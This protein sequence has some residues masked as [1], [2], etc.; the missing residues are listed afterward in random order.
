MVAF[1]DTYSI[2]IIGLACRLPKA[3]DARAFWRNLREGVDCITRF[4]IEEL[5]DAGVPAAAAK[6]PSYVRAR[7]IIADDAGFDAALFGMSAR[8]AE[9]TDP[10]QRIWL[11]CALSALEDAGYDPRRY[12]GLI[13]V[14]A[15][16]GSPDY[17]LRWPSFGA[18][19]V[20]SH[21]V[22]I[23]NDK[24]FAA[25]RTSY[26]L[27]LRGPS[28]SLQSACSTSLAAI[29]VACQQ[30]LGYQCDMAVA[31]GA[32]LSIPSR[33]GYWYRDG[34]IL[35]PDGCCRAFDAR[36]QGTV[37]GDGVGALVLKRLPDALADGDD[38]HAVL[39]GIAVNNDG[40]DKPGYTAPS[41][42]GQRGVIEQA[43]AFAGISASAV[44]FVE[45]HGTGTPLGDPIEFAALSQVFKQAGAAPRSCALGSV[46]TNI[47]HLNVAAGVA[48][49]IKAVLAVKHRAIPPTLYFE[50]PNPAIALDDSAFYVNRELRPWSIGGP[51]IAGVSSFG[52]GGTNAHAIVSEPPPRALIFAS[53]RRF[54]IL[55]I[56]AMTPQAVVQIGSS[57]AAHLEGDTP[58]LAGV[59]FTLQQGR[60]ERRRRHAVVVNDLDQAV[61]RLRMD[62]NPTTVSHA[63]LSVGFLL[64]GQG[65]QIPGMVAAL[66]REEPQVRE[67]LLAAE[68][69][70]RTE[71]GL[72]MMEVLDAGRALEQ[73][74]QVQPILFAVEYALARVLTRWGLAPAAL[75][76]HSLGEYVAACLAGVFSLDEGL[77]LVAERGRL[78]QATAPGAMLSVPLPEAEV[79]P[80]LHGALDLAAVNGAAQC[81]VS[82]EELAIEELSRALR[83][84]GIESRRLRTA[85]AFHS[86][87][88]DPIL[89][90]FTRFLG[91]I[92][93]REPR[94]EFFSCL[95]G[96]LIT[97]QAAT[98]PAY[99]TQQLRGTVRFDA[100]LTKLLSRTNFLIEVGPGETLSALARRHPERPPEVPVLTTLGKANEQAGEPQ[101]WLATVAAAWCAGA[102]IDWS[103][104]RAGR[105]VCR[106]HLPSY[107]FERQHYWGLRLPGET[108]SRGA[109]DPG[110]RGARP[111]TRRATS[112]GSLTAN[113]APLTLR[114]QTILG[115]PV[116]VPP[117]PPSAIEPQ[118]PPR[119]PGPP[120]WLYVPTWRAVPADPATD[121]RKGNVKRWIVFADRQGVGVKLARL[122][123]EGTVVV[124]A[125]TRFEAL[126]ERTFVV[127]PS[128]RSDFLKLLAAVG[129]RAALGVVHAYSL[130]TTAGLEA[131]EATLACSYF[132]VVALLQALGSSGASRV[133]LTVLTAGA[134]AA[135]GAP[136]NP[137]VATLS[138]LARVAPVEYPEVSFRLLDLAANELHGEELVA[139]IHAELFIP[140]APGSVALR[141]GERLVCGYEPLGEPQV[142]PVP[143]LQEGGVYLITGGLGGIGITLAE[144]L[145]LTYR[146]RLVLVGRKGLA[147]ETEWPALLARQKQ[148]EERLRLEKYLSVRAAAAG[149]VVQ[150]ADVAD[151]ASARKLVE[152]AL[153]RFGRLDGVIHAAGVTGGGALHLRSEEAMRE[154]L[155]AKVQ[156]TLALDAA[157]A[158]VAIDFFMLCS[159]LTALIGG[160]GQADYA[161]ANA[162]LDAYA[163][164]ANG[165]D[166]RLVV[167]VNWD[168][169]RELGA[170]ARYAA[171]HQQI[172][173]PLPV[174][175]LIHG[176]DGHEEGDAY[177]TDL[178]AEH[179]VVA[180]HRVQGVRTLPGTLYVE[181][182]CATARA[183]GSPLPLMIRELTLAAPLAIPEG[184]RATLRTA[185]REEQ[186]EL[187]IRIESHGPGGKRRLHALA[188]IV[189]MVDPDE[190]AK[191]AQRPM[192]M[193]V[194]PTLL[195]PPDRGGDMGVPAR[196]RAGF[197]EVGPR[198]Q[199]LQWLT[200]RGDQTIARL[201]LPEPFAKEAD[202]FILHPSLFDAISSV[203]APREERAHLPFC[204]RNLIVHSPLG[205]EAYCLS[206][207]Y[208]EAGA[209]HARL[210]V[211]GDT[212]QL[213]VSIEDYVL[214]EASAR[215]EARP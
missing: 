61:R 157:L 106:V 161:A 23:G 205:S 45:A 136:T 212:G 162:F 44:S 52:I 79:L 97:S 98:D 19:P 13:G 7:G 184:E 70:L 104:M 113:R 168:G 95:S 138:G 53:N 116:G 50:K 122:L 46:K 120:G 74:E 103:A 199:C 130:E 84:R 90:R 12:P 48:G 10:Q 185:W 164:S 128:S 180:Q 163:E 109:V 208:A 170:A 181:L 177:R 210:R 173:R 5:I 204:Y 167:S 133:E 135:R 15:G 183:L 108:R 54:E 25:T 147:P 41:A 175:P 77:A 148:D 134:Q 110:S 127:D 99:W 188:R 89:E 155:R 123:G 174:H 214:R 66:A 31:G 72:S 69:V 21:Q 166:E 141:A 132:S 194:H 118:A 91:R 146:A 178:D 37:P 124:R 107:P 17:L 105:A 28:L 34:M 33:V 101:R 11:E 14:Y 156:G 193:P 152:L 71:L 213:L 111:R 82:G 192:E 26:K 195:A 92:H 189:K 27:N 2:A 32:S 158:G 137:T 150:A 114:T 29:A 59:A 47:G 57:L 112:T 51:L 186:G 73:T 49:L 215:P 8:E 126:D 171:Q 40:D 154:I 36:A 76:G 196:V 191:T 172:W 43:L 63:R 3:P 187:H 60:T 62:V 190:A 139:A 39:R 55:P 182:A 202:S 65:A 64:P 145:A 176:W 169:W 151:P 93:L 6:N 9:Q 125:G 201:R 56:S 87:L 42:A 207:E 197:I 16:V 143:L 22:L 78:M 153:D 18:D 38:I 80:L 1:D 211:V 119:L 149:V 200:S 142:P 102:S 67:E 88:M 165:R 115:A 129:S 209:I 24:D 35:S 198:W 83:D 160:F 100:A 58:P 96:D 85:R 68:A 94:V 144:H 203:V 121:L 86:R 81:V 131:V 206:T 140:S 30:L 159:S 4:G 117:A 179:W 20:A 75:L